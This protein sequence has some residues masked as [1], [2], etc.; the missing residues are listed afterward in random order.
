[1]KIKIMN[2]DVPNSNNRIYPKDVIQHAIQK[3]SDKDLYCTIGDDPVNHFPK[4]SSKNIVGKI[5][6]LT[7]SDAGDVHGT[8]ETMQTE[9]SKNLKQHTLS[10]D[11]DFVPCG[12]GDI[13]KAGRVFNFTFSSISMVA[14]GTSAF[15]EIKD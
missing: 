7:I 11:F 14:K 2:V 15:N 4:V 10:Q 1:M 13:D 8:L 3:V 6:N 12:Y 9:A 5:T